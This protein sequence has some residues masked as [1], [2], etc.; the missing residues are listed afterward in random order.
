[1]EFGKSLLTIL[2]AEM[3]AVNDYL[4]AKEYEAE[5]KVKAETAEDAIE[6]E[7]MLDF[8]AEYTELRRKSE[9]KITEARKNIKEYIN[10]I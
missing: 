5:Y 8:V 3:A 7:V 10:K 4:F 6:K 1:M 9:T 2:E